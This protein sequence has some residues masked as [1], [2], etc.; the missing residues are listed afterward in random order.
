M[1]QLCHFIYSVSLL[2]SQTQYIQNT[3]SISPQTS[4]SF[5]FK[6]RVFRVPIYSSFFNHLPHSIESSST[7]SVIS[8]HCL[9]HIINLLNRGFWLLASTPKVS[10]LR[11]LFTFNFS[12]FTPLKY[13]FYT[14]YLCAS[15]RFQR[16]LVPNKFKVSS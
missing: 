9:S 6:P 1:C 11:S 4:N 5:Y 13:F 10:F 12:S 14:S 16:L 8:L 15:Q 2:M 7:I 3:F